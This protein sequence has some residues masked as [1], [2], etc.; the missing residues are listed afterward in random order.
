VGIAVLAVFI[1]MIGGIAY[2]MWR[3][4][5]KIRSSGDGLTRREKLNK[6]ILL[7][8]LVI[9]G[10]GG[11]LGA[12]TGAFGQDFLSITGA[13]FG[14]D[15]LPVWVAI[16]CIFVWGVIMP[17]L[18]WLWHRRAIDEQ[19]EAAYRDGAYYAAYS[20]LFAAPIWWVLWRS[21]LLP[22]PNGIAFYITFTLIW[23]AVWFWKKY[24]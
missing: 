11:A 14:D 15:P 8:F 21:G 7:I 22:E 17:V 12:A 24:R 4:G 1:A 9:G 6:Q 16:A 10:V 19:E 13:F 3:T 5:R 18:A 23:T 2:A 20:L